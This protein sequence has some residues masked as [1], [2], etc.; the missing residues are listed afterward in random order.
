M[1]EHDDKAYIREL[2]YKWR[3]GTLSGEERAHLERWDRKQADEILT[4]DENT[5]PNEI[6]SRLR[7]KVEAQMR[8]DL[9]SK[10]Q[11]IRLWTRVI[12]VAAI[13]TLVI[14]GVY[15]FTDHSQVPERETAQAEQDLA[16]GQVGATLTLASGRKIRLKDVANGELT[17]ESGL[18][19]TKTA[20]GQ[21]I[22]ELK[23]SRKD[24]DNLT[25][26]RKINTLSTAK[27]ETY[28]VRLPDGSTV[29]LNAASSLTYATSLIERGKRRV[30]LQG[31][32]YFEISKDARH[33][34]IV[35][36]Y[37]QEVEVLGTHFNIDAYEPATKTTLAEGSIKI[38]AFGK[39]RIIKPDQQATLS[40]GG[41]QLK[42]V[43]A[44][45]ALAWK[46][47]FFTFNRESLESLMAKIA[48]WYDV[49][50]IYHDPILKGRTFS[51]TIS[52]FEK[53]S[54]ILDMLERTSNVK[55][56]IEGR[57]IIIYKN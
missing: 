54:K 38:T 50:V 19:I 37:N 20:D 40:N 56:E 14:S 45:F 17:N 21:I 39:S 47:G 12:T 27:G 7:L 15:F 6:L 18:S 48:R 52:R 2:T 34:F 30:T 16:P 9:A 23:N 35:H 46:S 51:G 55:F 41:I 33:P 42:D 4:L 44:E 43:D 32:G 26:E 53:I 57:K 10:R 31:E 13:L 8:K 3:N 22:Y 49:E 28:Q 24:T 36:T 5:D 25:E 1:E 11:N 29:F